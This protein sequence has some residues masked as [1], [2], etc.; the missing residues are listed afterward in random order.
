V[1]GRALVGALQ[2]T[3]RLM[4]HTILGAAGLLAA[5][6]DK[7]VS[8]RCAN[9]T[10]LPVRGN[11]RPVLDAAGRVQRWIGVGRN[12]TAEVVAWP[13]PVRCARAATA[14][15]PIHALPAA[16]LNHERTAA[17]AAG[18]NGF[19]GRPVSESEPPRA[20]WPEPPCVRRARGTTA[21]RPR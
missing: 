4:G 19:I 17:V 5:Y 11:G 18:M 15:L 9:G 1:Q 12:V 10:V 2:V 14:P 13:P 7:V 20:P 8:M 16:V 21:A 6:R 3:D